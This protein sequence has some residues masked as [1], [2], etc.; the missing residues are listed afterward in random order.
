MKVKKKF[1]AKRG[2]K[3]TSTVPKHYREH[4]KVFNLELKRLIGKRRKINGK[5]FRFLALFDSEKDANVSAN[6]HKRFLGY[7]ET[8]V[9]REPSGL[10]SVWGRI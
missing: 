5:V 8:F 4:T 6:L 2:R 9:F 1:Y 10:Y 7:K 3:S